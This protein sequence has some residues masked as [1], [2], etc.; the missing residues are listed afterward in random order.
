[1]KRKRKLLTCTFLNMK[2]LTVKINAYLA[3]LDGRR[4]FLQRKSIYFDNP[5]IDDPEKDWWLAGY[6]DQFNETVHKRGGT[7]DTRRSFEKAYKLEFIPGDKAKK[8]LGIDSDVYHEGFSI[9]PA[10]L[11]P[12]LID[13]PALISSATRYAVYKTWEA[14]KMIGLG[15]K[16]LF[17]GEVS[18]RSLGGPI[19]I[20]QL[21]GMA[22]E[23][24]FAPYFS[25]MALISMNL[26]L[27]NLFP[28]PVLDGGQI[29]F[30]GIEA[31]TR[32]KISKKVKERVLLV[33]V[34]MLMML[35]VFAIW[36]D[37]SRVLLGI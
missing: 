16:L 17:K 3:Y 1:M 5:Y 4:A 15:F 9:F 11:K 20:G 28:I 10:L 8:D 13:N 18:L 24:G 27:I 23:A 7:N 25:M 26:G 32:R 12:E 34:A 21:A 14:A 37:I 31:V 35:M 6:T 19:M 33:G 2:S 30:L 22:A 36:N 29:T